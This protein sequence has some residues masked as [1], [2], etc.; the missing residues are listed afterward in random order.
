[1]TRVLPTLPTDLTKAPTHDLMNY[2]NTKLAEREELGSTSLASNNRC[3]YAVD[4]E[5]SY[6]E[7]DEKLS[8]ITT[9]LIRRHDK[10]AEDAGTR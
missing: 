7:W 9:E 4:C 2:L 10:G 5:L 3:S 1:M 8:A 6:P